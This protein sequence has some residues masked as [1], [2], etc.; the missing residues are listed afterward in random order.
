MKYLAL[1]YTLL[2]LSLQLLAGDRTT[3]PEAINRVE[4]DYSA[5]TTGY[6][7]EPAD[8]NDRRPEGKT[9][10]PEVRSGASR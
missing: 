10:R 5:L 1:G 3:L 6:I 2:C 4:P 7:V 8:R 9:I